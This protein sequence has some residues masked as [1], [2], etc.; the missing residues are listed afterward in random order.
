MNSDSLSQSEILDVI[1]AVLDAITFP[2]RYNTEQTRYCVLALL[3][4]KPREGLLLGKTSLNEGARIHDVLEFVRHDLGIPVAEDTRE[5][6]RKTSLKHLLD[7]GLITR[8]RSSVND[9]KTH[10]VLHRRFEEQLRSCI[11]ASP[12]ER[13]KILQELSETPA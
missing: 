10:Y 9:P 1:E 7:R 2:K 11:A 12:E 6:Y 13:Q 5:S 4:R 3:D 8:H